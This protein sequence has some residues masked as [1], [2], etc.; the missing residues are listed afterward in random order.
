[1]MDIEAKIWAEDTRIMMADLAT[2]DDDTR[3]LFLKKR[4]EIH[5]VTSDLPCA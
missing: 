3:A 2:I 5:V 1:M 4:A